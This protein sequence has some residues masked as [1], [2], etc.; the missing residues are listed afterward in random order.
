MILDLFRLPGRSRLMHAVAVSAMASAGLGAV[1]SPAPLAAQNAPAPAPANDVDRAVDA[2]RAITTMRANFV[3]TDR[4]GQSLSGVMTMKRPGKIR[5]QYERGVPLLIVSDGR[6]L[7]LIDY[8]VRQVQRWPIRNS[9]LGA[10][11]DP[12]KD[13]ARF[14]RLIPTNHS[15]VV[16]IEVRDTR[17]PEYGTIT[18]IFIRKAS[19]PGGLELDSWVALDS[20]N[21]RTTVRLSGQQYGI[22]V[23]ENTFRWNDPRPNSPKH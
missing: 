16:S 3:Q 7:T 17:H 15:S 14:A 23:P 20:Q 21:K 22:D 6:A 10:L 13:V 2:L 11:L 4:S 19:A 9:P 1:M 8:E 12:S 5:F 18:L